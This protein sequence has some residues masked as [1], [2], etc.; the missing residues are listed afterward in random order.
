M[1]EWVSMQFIPNVSDIWE[2]EREKIL[3][4]ADMI[5]QKLVE[6]ANFKGESNIDPSLI[7]SALKELVQQFDSKNGGL[8][9]KA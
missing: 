6:H 2:N 3:N 9:A 4:S 1:A 7:D 8:L 5:T